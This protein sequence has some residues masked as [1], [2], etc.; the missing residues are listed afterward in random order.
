MVK[1]RHGRKDCA[2]EGIHKKFQHTE[3]DLAVDNGFIHY[4]YLLTET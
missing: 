2:P 4:L 1:F 3:H